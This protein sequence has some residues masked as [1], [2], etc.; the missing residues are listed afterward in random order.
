MKFQMNDKSILEK[1]ENLM[2]DM[3]MDEKIG[4]LIYINYSCKEQLPY[5]ESHFVGTVANTVSAYETTKL[6]ERAVKA[7]PH[8]IPLLIISDVIQGFKTPFPIPLAQ[9]CSFDPDIVEKSEEIMAREANA[10][11]TSWIAGPMVDVARDPRW[12]R[13]AEGSGEDTYLNSVMGAARV[14]GLNKVN[15]VIGCAKHFMGYGAAEA[16]RDYNTAQ[17][18]ENELMNIYFPPFKACVDEGVESIMIG[19]HDCLG[20]PM[21]ANRHLLKDILRDKAGFEG[22]LATDY[23]AISQL[24]IHGVAADNKEACIKAIDAGAE[25]DMCSMV[26]IEELKKLIESG[27]VSEKWLNEACAKVLYLKYYIG[28]FDKYKYDSDYEKTITL[29]PEHLK[30]SADSARSSMV[31]L[32]NDGVLPLKGNKCYVTGPLADNNDAPLGWWRCCCTSDCAVSIKDAL[33]SEVSAGAFEICESID[34]ADTIIAVMGEEPFLSGEA[35]CRAN[36]KLPGEQEEF[37]ENLIGTGKNVVVV[38]IAGRPLEITAFNDRVNAVLMAWQYGW[39]GGSVADILLGKYNPSGRLAASFPRCAGQIPVYYNHKNTG[40][41]ADDSEKVFTEKVTS[42]AEDFA[43]RFLDVPL[44]PLYSF[45]HGLSYTTFAYSD[46]NVDI[47]SDLPDAPTL[48]DWDKIM[49]KACVCV[50]NEGDMAGYETVQLYIRDLSAD[51]SR[52][53]KELKGFERIYLDPG[54]EKKVEINL[55]LKSFAYYDQA[56]NLRVDKGTFHLWMSHDSTDKNYI[57]FQIK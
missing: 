51:I 13:I 40:R 37:L 34:D 3:T 56:N 35:H 48:T 25:L 57:E 41:P 6:Q 29:C 33:A 4:Q 8:N 17:V 52:P 53:V 30:V 43:S 11:G 19:F 36:I 26:F 44:T 54:E 16:G 24:V 55:T 10:A 46:L 18:S 38:I 50:K 27:E 47:C 7:S 42:Y 21:T 20:V 28:L 2:S 22:W 5:I 1:I 45:G 12:G 31:L 23:A 14:R 39:D 32:K 9:A 15:G 49:V